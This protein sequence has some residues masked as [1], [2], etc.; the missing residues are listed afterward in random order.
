MGQQSDVVAR[1]RRGY[2][3][4][5]LARYKI[6][7]GR[8]PPDDPLPDG[9]RQD[10]RKHTRH[11]LRPAEQL[12]AQYQSDP[13]PAAWKKFAEQYLLDLERRFRQDPAPYDRLVDQAC[14]G[15][16]F[17]GCSCPTKKNPD[18]NHCHT[19]LALRFIK[20]RYP[21]LQVTLP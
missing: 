13:T 8:R 11:C 7:R 6:Y 18:V 21:Q 3:E 12:V 2:D 16:V 17:I 15:D 14:E 1:F 5:M 9:I 20:K 10:T 19:I 4:Q